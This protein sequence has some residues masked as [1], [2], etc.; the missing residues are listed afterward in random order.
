MVENEETDK[1]VNSLSHGGDLAGV[2]QSPS[3][4]KH[5]NPFELADKNDA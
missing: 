4:A 1:N 3:P 5:G 2:Y